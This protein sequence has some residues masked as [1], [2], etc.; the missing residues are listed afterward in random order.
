M[1]VSCSEISI[2]GI[3]KYVKHVGIIRA[4]CLPGGDL[5]S[6]SRPGGTEKI[7]GL[8]FARG[9]STQADTIQIL[10]KTQTEVFQFLDFWSITYK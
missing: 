2:S 6:F 7:A 5:L 4:F 10:G 9:I 3:G 8:W 1:F